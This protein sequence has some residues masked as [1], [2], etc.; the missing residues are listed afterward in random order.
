MLGEYQLMRVLGTV[1]AKERYEKTRD[2][3]RLDVSSVGDALNN[4]R[5]KDHYMATWNGRRIALA[6]H[7][8]GSS[9][10]RKEEGF[11]LYFSYDEDA[12]LV[13]V[14]HFPTHLPNALT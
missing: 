9:S 12:E 8:S 11:R 7:V 3:L 6:L 1:E 10:R 4:H 2:G 14:G 5:T 13:V